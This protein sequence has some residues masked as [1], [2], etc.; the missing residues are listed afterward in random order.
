MGKYKI[1]LDIGEGEVKIVQWDGS[2]RSYVR[3]PTPDNL[4][5]DGR[6]VSY[7]AMG[8]FLSEALKENKITGKSCAV[9]IPASHT[10]LRRI[11]MAAMTVQQLEV[12]LPYEFRD[13]L[14]EGKDKYYY[15]YAVNEI[16]SDADG[17]PKQMD[18][19]AATVEKSVIGEY[20]DM[21]RRAGLRLDTAVPAECALANVLRESD[22]GRGRE[23]C[24]VDFGHSAT[25]VYIYSGSKFETSRTIEYGMHMVDEAVSEARGV[26]EHIARTYKETNF[27]GARSAEQ[28]L[29]VYNA[30]AVDI[31]K[32]VSFYLYN[33][34]ASN[35]SDIWYCGGGSYIPE[36]T[37]AVSRSTELKVH[38]FS[39]LLGGD[40]LA[41]YAA[42]IGA[43]MQ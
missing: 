4:V 25:R 8:D 13:Y 14:T 10:F 20:R 43:V 37:D 23:Y 1:G 26:D 28:A 38:P 3:V 40:H 30:V 15:D 22:S 39:S 32:A 35:L 24:V 27:E 17:S 33:N 31:R 41:P 11:T 18:I 2:V 29:G 9:V 5:K 16:I 36:L 7:E 42:A 6:I 34:R 21:L 12:N 19:T